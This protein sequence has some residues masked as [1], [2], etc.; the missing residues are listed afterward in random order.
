VTALTKPLFER[1]G[2][3]YQV[4]L[5]LVTE[6]ALC[7]TM[8]VGYNRADSAE[9]RRAADCYEALMDVLMKAGYIPYRAG[10]LAMG[11]LDRSSET[12]WDVAAAIKT[13]LDPDG[14]LAPGHYEPARARRGR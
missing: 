9:T 14:I 8:T 11:Q 5:S 12:F 6:R 3:E 1:H 2:F 4:T 10:N 13:T 7:A